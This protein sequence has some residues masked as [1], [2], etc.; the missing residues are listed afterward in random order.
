MR[1]LTDNIADALL[2]I[3]DTEDGTF[4]CA[5]HAVVTRLAAGLA[6]ERRLVDDDLD[7]FPDPRLPDRSPIAD[8]CGDH[9]L[10]SFGVIA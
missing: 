5:D 8:Q 1:E 7:R 10:G 2:R 3:G 6:I 9:T 4:R